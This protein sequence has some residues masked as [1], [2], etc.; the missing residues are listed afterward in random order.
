MT[1]VEERNEIDDYV[2]AVSNKHLGALYGDI[3]AA[4]PNP[5]ES[6]LAVV[7]VLS[8]ALLHEIE[9]WEGGDMP[10]AFDLVN[11]IFANGN[12]PHYRLVRVESPKGEGVLSGDPAFLEL[13]RGKDGQ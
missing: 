3:E 12:A 8:W 4:I 1:K 2:R 7:R 13:L 5:C 9:T 11:W 6:G 10:E